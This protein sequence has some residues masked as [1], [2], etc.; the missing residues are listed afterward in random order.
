MTTDWKFDDDVFGVQLSGHPNNASQT[1]ETPQYKDCGQQRSYPL[2]NILYG[3]EK[4]ILPLLEGSLLPSDVSRWQVCTGVFASLTAESS[5]KVTV[6]NLSTASASVEL[7][8]GG[9]SSIFLEAGYSITFNTLNP[10]NIRIRQTGG[11]G[12]T[13]YYIVTN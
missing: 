6:S 5:K 7:T 9:G 12:S 10:S 1:A 3:L 4:V 8:I 13:L 11:E 2:E